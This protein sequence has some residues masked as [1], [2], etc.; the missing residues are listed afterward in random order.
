MSGARNEHGAK[1]L[2]G[3]EFDGRVGEYAEKRG[4]MAAEEPAHACLGVDV[5]HCGHDAEP[6]AGV[7]RELRVGGLEEDFHPVERAYDSLGLESS[8]DF[9]SLVGL[10]QK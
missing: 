10:A 4:R 3:E 7:F 6:R 8:S 5:A 2:V 1:L 9:T